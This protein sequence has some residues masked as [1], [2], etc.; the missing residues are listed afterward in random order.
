MNEKNIKKELKK[1][2]GRKISFEFPLKEITTIKI[3]GRVKYYLA[4]KKEKDLISA[5]KFAKANNI[6]WHI[7]GDGSNLVPNDSGFAGLIIKNE[8][9][10]FKRNKNK[11]LVGAG[12]NLLRFILKLNQLGLAGMEKMAGIPGTIGGAIYGCAGAY[13]QEIKDCLKRVKFFDGKKLCWLSKKQCQFKYRDSVF[14]KKDWVIVAAE[15]IFRKGD[16]KK[17]SKISREIIK[18]RNQKYSKKLFTPGSFFKNIVIKSIKPLQLRKKFLSKINKNKIIHGKVPAGY[19][20][21]EVG[22]KGMRIGNI[23]VAD[24]HGNL[25]INLGN[26]KT[27]DI[28]KLAKILKN[29]VKRKFGIELEEEVRYL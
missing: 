29:K 28:E 11:V 9:K 13:G 7:I 22:A 24:Y 23:K 8:I 20:L 19:L 17:L 25:I 1:I 18:I 12:N 16:P 6:K 4:V 15:F 27:S 3:G 2:F 5:I 10:E 26:G 14:K 21:E